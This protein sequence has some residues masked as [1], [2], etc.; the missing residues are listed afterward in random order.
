LRLSRIEKDIKTKVFNGSLSSHKRK[1][2]LITIAGTLLLLRDGTMIELTGRIKDFFAGNPECASQPRFVGLLGGNLTSECRY[3][4]GS[5][6]N[7][8]IF[9][10]NPHTQIMNF[11]IHLL[12]Y[13]YALKFVTPSQG[14][15]TEPISCDSHTHIEVIKLKL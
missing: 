9:Q 15:R 4:V 11:T 10:L 3:S 12:L 6:K 1:D 2:D 5:F 8:R 7:H 13:S 14:E